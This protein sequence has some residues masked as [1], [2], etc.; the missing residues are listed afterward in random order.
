MKHGIP[1]GDV[2]AAAVPSTI[3]A[4]V[5]LLTLYG[6]KSFEEVVQPT[7]AILDAGGASWY[8]DTGSDKKIETGVNWQKDIADAPRVGR[9][10][11]CSLIGPIARQSLQPCR[12]IQE[13]APIVISRLPD[14]SFGRILHG[15]IR[16]NFLIYAVKFRVD[17]PVS[18]ELPLF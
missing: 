2:K 9:S 10:Q 13:S 8:I 4:I 12:H 5:T 7:L 6:T 11:I 15:P 18:Y 3:D 1:D 17:L 16:R 14:L